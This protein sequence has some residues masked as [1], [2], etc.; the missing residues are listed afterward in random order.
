MG[1]SRNIA[2]GPIAFV[3]LLMGTLLQD[4]IDPVKNP[5]EYSRLAFTATFFAGITQAILG[6]FRQVDSHLDIW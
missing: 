3:S 6:F 2:I 5:I 4:E 1:S